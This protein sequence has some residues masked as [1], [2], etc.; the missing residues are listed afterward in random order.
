[1]SETG[2]LSFVLSLLA[3][4]LLERILKLVILLNELCLLTSKCLVLL[5]QRSRVECLET[6]NI[7]LKCVSVLLSLEHLLFELL[8]LVLMLAHLFLS[9]LDE[10]IN[11][12]RQSITHLKPGYL[13]NPEYDFISYL[14]GV[15]TF[16]PLQSEV[17]YQI[18]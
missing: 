7:T 6:F 5:E 9:E 4:S 17:L 15:P 18:R 12:G 13:R 2:K 11:E 14:F 10:V 1:M 8:P 16:N 3:F